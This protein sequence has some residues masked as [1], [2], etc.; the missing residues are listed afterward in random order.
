MITKHL[1]KNFWNDF[2]NEYLE[3]TLNSIDMEILSPEKIAK[4]LIQKEFK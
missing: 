1:E 4:M 3:K 2:T